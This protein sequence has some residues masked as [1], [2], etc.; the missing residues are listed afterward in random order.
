MKVLLIGN[1][2]L[3][4]SQ[5]MD[6]FAAMLEQGIRERGHEARLLRPKPRAGKIGE[7]SKT[8]AKWLGYVDMFLLFKEDLKSA[9]KWADVVHICDQANAVY[10][11]WLGGKPH[12][13]T[14]HD[15]IAV[16]SAIGDIPE[17]NVKL[18]GR[19]Y[20]KW[21][22]NSLKK[23]Q[24]V[25]CVSETTQS[26]LVRLCGE[27]Q[28]ETSV[29]LNGLN[30]AY[31][32]MSQEDQVKHL[33]EL[34]VPPEWDFFLHVGGNSFYKNKL[35]VIGIFDR[36]LRDGRYAHYRLVM[37]GR[38]LLREIQKE[39]QTLGISGKIVEVNNPTNEQLRA[40]Y[41]SARGLIFPSLY[42]GFGWPIIEAQAC[43][44]P[45]FTSN[46]N[47]MIEI[48]GGGAVYV[49]PNDSAGAAR[50]IADALG[51]TDGMVHLGYGNAKK[52]SASAMVDRYL[53]LYDK[54]LK[55]G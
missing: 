30:Y 47:P 55:R 21:I 26:E 6:R 42:E 28:L 41:S 8:A 14:C 53:E 43:G 3:L 39:A 33:E 17:N 2:P 45:V 10:V 1:Y 44:C 18:T 9:L 23:A 31:A 11:P 35:G 51:R 16:K 34:R 27:T 29:I 4:H 22:L 50:V 46:R 32:P 24:H 40:L 19:A 25:A 20:Q 54:I 7:T 13:V 37:A 52:F 36:L 12:V 49:D 48:G 15:M 5:S 38:G